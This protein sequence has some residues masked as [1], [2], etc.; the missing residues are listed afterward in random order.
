M[1]QTK[2]F[3]IIELLIVLAILGILSA[4]AYPMYANYIVRAACDNGKAGLM[5]AEALLNQYYMKYGS[6]D[7]VDTKGD[8]FPIKEIPIDGSASG[9]DFSIKI[10]PLTATTYTITATVKSTGRLGKYTGKMTINQSGEKTADIG[11][12]DVW[13]EG[14]SSL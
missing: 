12:K 8:K 7:N 10:D 5:Q 2:G 14:C 6:Y 4:I 1:K 13:V 9:G 11:G 3:S